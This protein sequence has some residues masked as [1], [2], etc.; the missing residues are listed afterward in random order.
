MTVHV[1]TAS[2]QGDDRTTLVSYIRRRGKHTF[3]IHLINRDF[4]YKTVF[5]FI[6]LTVDAELNATCRGILEF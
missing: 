2:M 1:T 6:L 4:N 3:I 5:L